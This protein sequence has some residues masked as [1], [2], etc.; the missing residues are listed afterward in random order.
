M[1]Y[2]ALLLIVAFSKLV[3][4][5]KFQNFK[6]F[7]LAYQ[8]SVATIASFDKNR[9]ETIDI[10]S[11]QNRLLKV[12]YVPATSASINRLLFFFWL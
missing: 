2:D 9:V 5:D 3:R 4:S 6:N 1:F 12:C 8:G 10:K 11:F 7:E